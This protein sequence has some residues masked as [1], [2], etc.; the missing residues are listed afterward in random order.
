MIRLQD[1]K[2]DGKQKE[3]MMD[4]LE[5]GSLQEDRFY[6]DDSRSDI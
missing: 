1:E 4:A 3:I 5:R 2:N 6:A